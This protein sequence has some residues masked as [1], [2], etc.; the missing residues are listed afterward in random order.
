MATTTTGAFSGTVRIGKSSYCIKGV[1][2]A[3]GR[4]TVS[5]KRKAPLQPLTINIHLN[6]T[7]DVDSLSC[8]ISDQGADYAVFA[9]RLAILPEIA[10]VAGTYPMA[11]QAPQNVSQH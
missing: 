8:T 10:A 5:V 3:E 1:L 9:S 11:L 6:V 2:D 4:A 7:G